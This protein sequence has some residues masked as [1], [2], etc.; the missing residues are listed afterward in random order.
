[1]ANQT[2]QLAELLRSEGQSVT[3]VPCNAPYSPRWVANV[4]VLRAVFRLFP[5]VEIVAGKP[6]R[7][8]WRQVQ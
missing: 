7:R 5:C 8:R 4:P 3:L 2:Q 6:A 1:M